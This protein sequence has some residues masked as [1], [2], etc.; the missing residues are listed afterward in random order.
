ML[1]D[2]P[3]LARSLFPSFPGSFV[4]SPSQSAVFLIRSFAR[5]SLH[6]PP[7]SC[8]SHPLPPSLPHLVTG[9][10]SQKPWALL[11]GLSGRELHSKSSVYQWSSGPGVHINL[12]T[13]PGIISGCL[14]EQDSPL[15][16]DSVSL[17]YNEKEIT[18]K[19]LLR[20]KTKSYLGLLSVSQEPGT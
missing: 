3:S 19:E 4:H 15:E 17:S 16:G 8:T 14:R 18:L 6:L 9:N 1:L 13:H 20:S 2:C 11:L 5:L 10:L 12:L 7:H